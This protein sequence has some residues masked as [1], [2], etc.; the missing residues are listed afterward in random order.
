MKKITLCLFNVL[1][2]LLPCILFAQNTD[3]ND[4][5]SHKYQ[6]T[7]FKCSINGNYVEAIKKID[8]AIL[9]APYQ[10]ELRSERAS[11]KSQ[12]NSYSQENILTDYDSAIILDPT[13]PYLYRQRG[14][15]Y[16]TLKKYKQAIADLDYALK[17]HADK[18]TFQI[19]FKIKKESNLFSKE[20]LL[21]EFNRIYN[22][23]PVL[24]I[25]DRAIKAQALNKSEYYEE[26]IKEY[27]TIIAAQPTEHTIIQG[28][29]FTEL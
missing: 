25:Q 2:I 19:L 11:F 22:D 8:S 23:K 21:A 15:Y 26:A 13:N 29:G 27:D 24:N 16:K 5:L 28:R 7:A 9:L 1:L 18:S 20:E 6:T 4:I 12:Y 17:I 10:G 14:W 3:P